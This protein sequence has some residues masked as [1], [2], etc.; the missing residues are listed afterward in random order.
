MRPKVFVVEG[1]NDFSRLKQLYPDIFVMTTNGSEISQ[2]SIDAL[3]K[4]D[5]T[6]DIIL[7]LDPDYAG[8]RIRNIL[9][10]KLEHIYH[11]FIDQD[12][13]IS[14]NQ[15]KIGVEHAKKEDIEDALKHI[16]MV[17]LSNHN[18]I[19][20]SFL[21]DVG[22]IG[23]N[24]SRKLRE[25]LSKALH[26]GHVNGKTLYHRLKAFGINQKDICEVISCNTKQKNDLDKTF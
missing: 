13:A 18:D 23:N 14:K 4:L 21:Y 19:E 15:K 9:S 17:D 24:H 22:L 6:H 11:A 12:K 5:E 1:K 8:K 3:M 7:F 16:K 10:K 20:M 2:E 25:K 26:I